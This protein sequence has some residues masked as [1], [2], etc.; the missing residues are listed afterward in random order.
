MC[1]TVA[2]ALRM[3]LRMA[4]SVLVGDE[5]TSS[6]SLYTCAVMD[7]LR[8]GTEVARSPIDYDAGRGT[9]TAGS[10]TTS[11]SRVH[12]SCGT[13]TTVCQSRCDDCSTSTSIWSRRTTGTGTS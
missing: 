6:I 5:P 7:V 8:S 12:V 2:D 11:V 1:F 13:S 10:V 3:A 9:A 4:S